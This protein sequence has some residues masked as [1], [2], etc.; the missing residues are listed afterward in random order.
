MRGAN[1]RVLID[2]KTSPEVSVRM[3]RKAADWIES[4]GASS[5]LPVVVRRTADA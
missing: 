5:P 1:V 2:P 4:G 3:L